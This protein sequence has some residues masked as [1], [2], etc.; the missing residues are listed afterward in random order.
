M[1]NSQSHQ[2]QSGTSV[3]PLLG[4]SS[5]GQFG[6]GSNPVD[7]THLLQL[8]GTLAAQTDTQQGWLLVIAP[9]QPLTKSILGQ[10]NINSKRILVI[11]QRQITHF[12]NLMR[13]ALTCST[14]CAVV[15]FLAAEHPQLEDY[16]YLS[17]KYGTALVNVNTHNQQTVT[18]H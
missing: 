14:C 18:T 4:R 5:A 2:F 1:L 17:A 11:Q 10:L 3:N 8:I 15:S 7:T 9:P 16:Q 6:S 12:D 13:D